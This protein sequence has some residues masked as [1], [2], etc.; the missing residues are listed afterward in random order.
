M[1]R[2]ST[3]LSFGSWYSVFD[4]AAITA[5][6]RGR[7][8][9]TRVCAVLPP[10]FLVAI[11]PVQHLARQRQSMFVEL[12]RQRTQLPVHWGY[13]GVTLSGGTIVVAPPDYHLLVTANTLTL[14]QAPRINHVRPSAD[15]LFTSVALRFQERALGVVL[16]GTSRNG[17][18]GMTLL[19]QMG[20]APWSRT[21]LPQHT[22]ACSTRQLLRGV[23]ILSCRLPRS[24]RR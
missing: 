15:P 4:I 3:C 23:S 13:E 9:V 24:P 14:S 16:T 1:L 20:A 11:I 21:R 2:S 6:T 10:D 17:A 18:L 22:S 19:K 5:A 12:L 8:A 7:A